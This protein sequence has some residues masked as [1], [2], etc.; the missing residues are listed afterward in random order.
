MSN[1]LITHNTL[2]THSLSLLRRKDDKRYDSPRAQVDLSRARRFVMPYGRYMGYYAGAIAR[3]D[4]DY[5]IWLYSDLVCR[6]T[7]G[8]FDADRIRITDVVRALRKGGD[9]GK[10]NS[11]CRPARRVWA[12]VGSDGGELGTPEAADLP[13]PDPLRTG[14]S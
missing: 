13:T 3:H 9:L 14:L 8:A 1:P 4:P 7:E 6:G 10:A 2:Y 12:E 5:L 11:G